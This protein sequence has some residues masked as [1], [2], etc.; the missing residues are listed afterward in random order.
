M[1]KFVAVLLLLVSTTVFANVD[2]RAHTKAHKR[3]A[4]QNGDEV[5]LKIDSQRRE[6]DAVL[7]G[8]TV[9]QDGKTIE[10]AFYETETKTVHMFPA[11]EVTMRDET[12][13]LVDV[14]KIF[15]IT[16]SE[17]QTGSTCMAY[18]LYNSMRQIDYTNGERSKKLH[19]EFSD[20]SS[21]QRFIVKMISEYYLEQNGYDRKVLIYLAD[22]Y[23]IDINRAERSELGIPGVRD[24]IL[25][26][27]AK[28]DP[29]LITFDVPKFMTDTLYEVF[30]HATGK[31]E[32][33]GLWTPK[34]EG[35]TGFGGHA[36]MATGLITDADDEE[37]MIMVDP[38]WSTPRLWN[39][40]ELDNIKGGSIQ[41]WILNDTK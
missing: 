12:D 30:M 6:H 23:G 28:R 9:R 11:N 27:L 19:K 37:W 15:P 41:A 8:R 1:I 39:V 22:T 21:R 14:E 38:N 25:T 24:A 2:V 4:L 31:A 13:T 16:R 32:S 7:L 29:V 35:R 26:S 36:V 20:E 18:T 3:F 10:V 40:T 33:R 34:K 17:E 5:T